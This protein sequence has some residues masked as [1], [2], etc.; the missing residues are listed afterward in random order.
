MTFILLL[1]CLASELLSTYQNL[2]SLTVADRSGELVAIKPNAKGNYARYTSSLPK[3]FKARL[4][5]KEDRHFY[6]HTGLNPISSLRALFVYFKTGTP[7]ASSTITQQLV[8][9]L[10]G[11]EQERTF[12]NKITE[13]FYALALELFLSKEKILNMYSNTVYMGN[14]IQGFDGASERYFGKKLIDLNDTEELSLLATVSSPSKLNPWRMENKSEV[15]RLSK[16]LGVTSLEPL[17]VIKEFQAISSANFELE[18][19]SSCTKSCTVTIDKDLTDRLREVLSRNVA[20]TSVYGGRNGAI[21]VIKLPENELLAIIGTFDTRSGINGSAINMAVKPRPI[22]S[23]IKPFIYLRAFEKGLRPYTLVDDREYKFSIASGFP[24]YP[25][26]YDG[27][28]RGRIT[29]HDALSNSLNVPTVKTLEYIG[30]ENFYSFLEQD[31]QFKPLQPME[32]YQYGIA[33]GGLEVDTLTLAHFMTLFGNGGELKPLKLFK[34]GSDQVG[35]AIAPPME[36]TIQSRRIT[37]KKY[38]E[39]VNKIT[40]DRIAGVEQFGLAGNLNLPQTNYSVKTGTSRDFHD[41]WTVGFTPDFLVAVWLGNVENEPMRQITSSTG[42]GKIWHDSMEVLLNSEYNKKTPL[43][44]SALVPY[45]IG[46]KIEYGLPGDD[47]NFIENRLFDTS[48]V[49]NPHDGDTFSFE[50][51]MEISL[52]SNSRVRWF[53]GDTFL[54]E[55]VEVPFHP[56]TPAAYTLRAKSKNME[57]SIIIRVVADK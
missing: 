9:N 29:L 33:L 42:A 17:V 27:I 2:E 57:E 8:K 37:D 11:N 14:G 23:T 36:T 20:Q 16:R 47:I 43:D 35:G 31:L 41:T 34:D 38:V 18:S 30:L 21:V 51:G 6:W 22:G 32:S 46:G 1:Y 5:K 25:K 13:V 10:L 56:L 26:N 55:G 44:F 54:G 52:R 7:G 3:D 28:Y 15:E 49:T 12:T 53:E 40:S 48:L 45:E 4:V 39:L 50:S 19:L 24:L